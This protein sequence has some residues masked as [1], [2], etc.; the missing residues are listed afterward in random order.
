[1]AI[2]TFSVNYETLIAFCARGNIKC[3]ELI[4]S[5]LYLPSIEYL[6]DL[7]QPQIPRQLYGADTDMF[8]TKV[9]APA[10]KIARLEEL[11]RRQET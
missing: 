1:M 7:S 9:R 8:A 2:D 4:S 6:T 5:L 3:K 10:G 11:I